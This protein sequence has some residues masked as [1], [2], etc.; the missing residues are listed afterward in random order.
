[1]SAAMNQSRSSCR[2]SRHVRPGAA[3][4]SAAWRCCC[5]RC[6]LALARARGARRAAEA[7]ER[8]R[9]IEARIDELA[10]SERRARTGACGHRWRLAWAR[11]R[12]IWRGVMAERLDNVGARVGAGLETHAQTTGANLNKLN[13]RLAVIDAAQA[14]LTGLT[15]GGRFAE[16]HSGQQADAR[17]FRP[18]PHGG[19]RARRP[20]VGRLRVSVHALQQVA[21]RLRHP[22][23]RRRAAAGGRRQVPAR[24]LH[25]V[26]GGARRRGAQGRRRSACAPTSAST[27]RTSPS[28]ISRRA[29]RRTSR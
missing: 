24:S 7:P 4:R 15:A 26:Q 11:A 29:R 2:L 13:E 5:S 6:L 10:R 18:G 12:P 9:E 14:R 3:P 22:P 16:G 28:A 23:A 27:S 17:R 20:A 21:A 8:Q 1:M 19:D 25:L